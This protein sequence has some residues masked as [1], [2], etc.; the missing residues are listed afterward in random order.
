MQRLVTG[1]GQLKHH[2]TDTL[3]FHFPQEGRVHFVT[4]NQHL[5][6]SALLAAAVNDPAPVFLPGVAGCLAKT[7]Q[8][9]FPYF[10]FFSF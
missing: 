5:Y 1:R 2:D 10:F 8:I 3:T 9:F 4:S 6:Q 7:K